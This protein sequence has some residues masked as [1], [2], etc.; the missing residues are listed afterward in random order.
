[1][2]TPS[3]KLDRRAVVIGLIV[4]GAFVVLLFGWQA[5]TAY[6]A[7]SDARSEAKQVQD[8]VH[9]GDFDGASRTLAGLRDDAHRAHSRTGGVLWDLGKHVPWVGK[10]I[11]AVQ[12]VSETLDTASRINAPIAL[13]LSVAV[14]NGT[15]RPVNGRIDL[16]QVAS[17]TP[18]V[19][20][21]ASSITQA[22]AKLDAI[23]ADD[24]LFP[25]ND[26]I[27][28]LQDQVD[29]ARSAS[30]ATSTAFDLM[31]QMLGKSGPRTYLLIVQNPAEVRA[32]GGLP[33]S[34]AILRADQGRVSMVR[35]GSA[36]DVAKFTAPVVALPQ[37]TLAMYG[38]TPASDFRDIN[39][40]PDWPETAQVA[41]TM[42]E[43][44]PAM[45]SPKVDGVI[46]VDPVALAYMMVGT[47]PVALP[48]GGS[49]DAGSVLPQLLNGVYKTYGNG[50]AQ[51]ALDQDN[52]FKAVAK[53]VFDAVMSGQGNQNQTIRY[54][55]TAAGEHRV[56]LW[57]A[58]P[59]EQARLDGTAVGGNLL[60]DTG[61]HPH[62][63]FYLNDS[64]ASKMDYY[65]RT[66]GAVSAVDCREHR[67]QD[68]RGSFTMTSTL[69]KNFAQLHLGESV[70]GS[71]DYSPQ[72]TIAFNL[73]IYAPKGGQ[74]TDMRVDGIAHSVTADK[75]H[76]R[77]VAFLPVVLKPEQSVTVTVDV[78]TADGQDG[79]GVFD[80]TPPISLDERG[81][82]DPAPNGVK[83]DSAC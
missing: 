45:G 8:Q 1:M 59:K 11:G 81:Q 56:L 73:R 69:P 10:N 37:D 17:L 48:T 67:A 51:D 78:R 7:L 30:V 63:G 35:Q 76:G 61:S 42:L 32:T 2:G 44:S 53:T 39:F 14:K 49:L 71:G 54:L 15:F 9:A 82:L 20:R 5:F 47:G 40:T 27:G 24:L 13:K 19:N 18:D 38:T 21:A 36:A 43:R 58:D 80:Y 33:G 52:Y 83:F 60:G 50:T 16:A 28:K 23:N 57:S 46:S 22:A 3:L 6:R 68:L 66:G 74:I 55:A 41:R 77:Q 70:L 4:V 31:P 25:F 12:T 65:L 79:S 26:M 34:I 62:V 29:E 72:G 64:T 75:D